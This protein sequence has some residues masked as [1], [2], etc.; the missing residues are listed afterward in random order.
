MSSARQRQ[1]RR[2]RQQV[3]RRRAAREPVARETQRQQAEAALRE[4]LQR[5]GRRHTTAYIMFGLAVVI[6]VGHF[7]QHWG[8]VELMD[9]ALAD[10][11]IGWPMAG[12]LAV[13]GALVYGK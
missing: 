3:D 9:P 1:L 13:A 2:E 12:V 5:Q 8:V 10:L 7:F 4:D 11:L 6:A